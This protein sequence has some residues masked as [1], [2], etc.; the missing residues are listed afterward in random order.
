MRGRFRAIAAYC[1]AAPAPGVA[2]GP[3]VEY[4]RAGLA[5]A[6]PHE[7]KVYVA[8]KIADSLRDRHQQLLRRSPE[9]LF[10][11]IERL[12]TAIFLSR[13]GVGSVDSPIDRIL[14]DQSV[15]RLKFRW[16]AAE[17]GRAA[18]QQFKETQ[19]RITLPDGSLPPIN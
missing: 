15:E 12:V 13:R 11:P 16:I 8:N 14:R 10:P 1:H 7:A 17:E 4:E 6:A 3:I 19:K 2:L 9:S 5:L 18:M